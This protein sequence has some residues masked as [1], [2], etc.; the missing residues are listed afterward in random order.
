M[1]DAKKRMRQTVQR[2]R[3]AQGDAKMNSAEKLISQYHTGCLVCLG[4]AMIFLA[5][6]VFLFVHFHIPALFAARS[7]RIRKRSIR[8]IEARNARSDRLPE[9]SGKRAGEHTEWLQ[10]DAAGVGSEQTKNKGED[11]PCVKNETELW[12]GC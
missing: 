5:V 9:L 3:S 2:I 6:T 8:E 1:P 12:P 11:E 7:G 4:L 10:W